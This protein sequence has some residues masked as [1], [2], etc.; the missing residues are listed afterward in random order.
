VG[1]RGPATGIARVYL[2][3]AFQIEVDTFSAAEVQD[4]LYSIGN[5]AAASHTLTI[6]ATGFERPGSSG[7][8]IVVDAFDVRSRFEDADP[9]VIYS[10]GW[11]QGETREAFSGTSERTGTGTAAFSEVVGAQATFAANGTSVSWIGSRGPTRGIARVLLDGALVATVDTYAATVQPQA[12]LYSATG[13]ADA[14]HTLTIEATGSKN[15][16]AAR[17]WIIV[18]A[19]DATLS[20]PAPPV[21]R[22]QETDAAIAW[23]AGW[24]LGNRFT[25]RS[26]ENARLSTT[27]GAQATFTFTGRAV[28]WISEREFGG[29]IARVY[30]DGTF[31]TEVDTY[32]PL[33]EE[34]QTPLFTAAN[35]SAGAHTLMIEVTGLKNP[36]SSGIQIVVDAFDVY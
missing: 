20:A 34:F 22:V 9:S 29:G 14:T 5:L 23:T 32:A 18:D 13:L 28:R 7:S 31:V 16:N 3:G 36:A 10:T 35:L 1:L 30:L 21:T 33:Q 27:G 15:A 2:D 12:V 6:E 26:G 17:A 11:T 25:L 19:F 4:V 24:T 8:L